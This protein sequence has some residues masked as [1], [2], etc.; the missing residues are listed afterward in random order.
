MNDKELMSFAIARSND[1]II[2]NPVLRDAMNKDLGPRTNFDDGGKVDEVIKAYKR[3]LGMRKGKQ[4]YKVIPFTKFFEEFARENFN[5]GGKSI[6]N[7]DDVRFKSIMSNPELVKVAE[8][9]FPEK[10]SKN[11][12]WDKILNTRER[13]AIN[14]GTYTL[15]KAKKFI[16]DKDIAKIKETLTK[17]EFAKLDFDSVVNGIS[18]R[19]RA[20]WLGVSSKKKGDNTKL[21]Q[22]VARILDGRGL[23]NPEREEGIKKRTADLLKRNNLINEMVTK[24]K[25]LNLIEMNRKIGL[26][27]KSQYIQDYI[28]NTFGQK[29]LF[30]I[31]PNQRTILE[32]NI[33]RLANSKPVLK[34]LE[35]GTLLDKNSIQYIAKNFFKNDAD[36]AGKTLFHMAEAA[37]G[38]KTYMKNLKLNNLKPFKK[39]IN[40]II[41]AAENDIF[42]NPAGNM[43]RKRKER[44]LANQIGEKSGFFKDSRTNLNK[45]SKEVF[46]EFG[47]K[48]IGTSV[49]EL[50]TITVPYKFGSPGYSVYQQQLTKTG[51]KVM[52]D[53]N[54]VKAKRLDRSLVDIRKALSNGTATQDM[55]DIYNQKV[56][57]IASDINK[58]VPKNGKKLQP[59]LIKL[60]GDPRKTV[61]NFKTLVEQNPLAA[62]NMLE[63]AKTQGWSG[64]IPAD[65][66]TI[67]DLRNTDNVK[68]EMTNS[69]QSIFQQKNPNKLK[70]TIKK[71][72]VKKIQQLF[73]KFGPRFVEAPNDGTR[74]T[75]GVGG[76]IAG[77]FGAEALA[78]EYGFYEASRRNYLSQ[79]YSEEEAKAMA[80]DEATLGITNKSDP[81]Y[82]KQLAQ[83]AKEMG[84]NPKA[85]DVLREISKREDK[86]QKQQEAD[87]KLIGSNYFQSKTEEEKNKFLKDRENLYKSY[88][89]ET[90]KLMRKARTDFGI[91]EAEKVFPN[92]NL[93][94]IADEVGY[95]DYD[96][97]SQ[98]FGDMQLAA[99]EKL[100]R[101]K[102]KAYDVQSTQVN[103]DQGKT[104]NL[105][106]NNLFNL[107]SIPRTLKTMYDFIDPSS[108]IPKL[109][110]LKSDSALEQDQ[111]NQM[112]NKE[113]YLY[114]KRREIEKDNPITSESYRELQDRFPEIGLAQGGLASLKR[115][116]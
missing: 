50:A 55:V 12:N 38:E 107:Q 7:S 6:R 3:Y 100:R 45:V 48:G 86:K 41:I 101:R 91:G 16:T 4:R 59:F 114:N 106:S 56:S 92:P 77:I 43:S 30:K 53:M 14:T 10:N 79:G 2:K 25:P 57:A 88:E 84:I 75:A 63:T 33:N 28:T 103:T 64:V 104:G 44:V 29:K 110:D 19:R 80:V 46:N 112:D 65:V 87:K 24:N 90:F 97:L 82:N 21:R 54:M 71:T 74:V 35:D 67:Y 51:D 20:G 68:K 105:I 89:D 37:K 116:I 76:F 13:S 49:D 15:E 31:F 26:N 98:N 60:G 9:Y 95:V 47:V 5:G 34:L 108:P 85:F 18:N 17:E 72:P 27:D 96:N 61:S 58:D 1:P 115:K 102:E 70:E 22:K 93:D 69:L 52:D 109:D 111:M 83:V 32:K 40:E 36:L 23:K 113:L 73:K 62:Q 42:G 94:Q 39:Q 11:V 78:F 81:A 99:I 8:A 66:P